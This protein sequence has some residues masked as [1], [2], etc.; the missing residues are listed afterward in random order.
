MTANCPTDQTLAA[1]TEG[2]LKRQEIASV[3][4]H[5]DTCMR[6]AHI[7]GAASQEVE[8]V[9]ERPATRWPWLAVA[10][11]AVIAIL[12]IPFARHFRSASVDDLVALAPHSARVIEPRLSGGFAYA[13]WRGP[14]RSD[15]GAR[16]AETMQLVGTAGTLMQRAD[17]D[18]SVEAQHDAGIALALV[19]EPLDAVTR[20][21]DAASRA[22][23]DARIWSD[24]AAAQYAAAERLGRPSMIPEALSSADRAVRVDPQFAEA[25]FN[26]AIIL[27]R[28]GLTQTA[29][30]A[31]QHY[32]D[33]DASSPWAAEARERLS[34]LPGTTGESLFRRDQPLLERAAETHDAARVANIVAEHRQQARTFGEAE[35]LGRWAEAKRRGD[36]AEATR[37]L[38]IAGGIGDALANVSGE[39]LL[40]DAVRAIA[41][42]K[43][44]PALA[45][46]HALY[47]QARMTY[48]RQQPSAAEP[49]LRRAATLFAR[50]GS[51]MAL[52]AR[53]FAA[54]ARYDRNDVD[55]AEDEL[56]ALLAEVDARRGAMALGAQVRWQ[57]ALCRMQADDWPA[58]LP[59][60]QEAA[61]AFR[62]LGERG[63]L[64]FLQTL[65][66]DALVCLARPEEAW[67]ARIESFR[68]LSAEGRGDRLL[69]SVGG[70]ARRE[71]RAGRFESARAL[72]GIEEAADRTMRNDLLLTNA[73]TREA[74]LDS[75]LG[76]DKS[77]T[78]HA[79]EAA[80]VAQ[81]I[82]DGA[83][84]TRA[85]I[86]V[87]FA[88]GAVLLAKDPRAA[89]DALTRAVDGYTSVE[90]PFYLPECYLLRT[91]ARMR[92]GDLAGAAA[93][94]ESGIAQLERHRIEYAGAV[95]GSGIFD[96]GRALYREAMSLALTRHD[97]PTA[98]AYAERSR[99]HAGD[100]PATAEEMRRRLAGSGTAV[101][102]IAAFDDEVVTFCLTGRDLVVHRV[103]I[104]RGMLAQLA[105]RTDAAARARL[106]DVLVRPSGN[107]IGGARHLV[108]VSDPELEGLAFGAL[109]D[110]VSRAYL[111]ER[112]A[113]S[114]AISASSLQR[115]DATRPAS[116]AAVAL[117]SGEA[118][119]SAAL[120][121]A[122]REL[123]AVRALYSRSISTE[124]ASISLLAAASADVVH[125]A[126]HTQRRGGADEAGLRFGEREWASWRSI[127]ASRFA[128][129]STIVLAACQS[130][131]R[132][133]ST[134]AFALSL[135]DAFLAAG[136]GD[137][138]GTL[139]VIA[140]NDAYE[141]FGSVHR[142]LAAGASADDAVRRAQLAILASGRPVAWQAVAVL[143][144]RI[145]TE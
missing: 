80:R 128:P 60:V 4:A 93:D 120:P 21:R 95:V 8:E 87:D 132:P 45:E 122:A 117:P 77:A 9:A 39:S 82:A 104:T 129:T 115:I 111:V 11:A 73:L 105:Q 134:H 106:Y 130:L 7:V 46:A 16:D 118:A 34:R 35:Y 42:T 61:R 79:D 62:A 136:A 88:R 131:R 29:R 71:L 3:V 110:S 56:V 27:E 51:P 112:L 140:D 44:L 116:V 31:W 143:T 96:A 30:D 103:R 48:G 113:V 114:S 24:L 142:E 89:I 17:R 67:T 138:I 2:R 12:S 58:S 32:L 85:L 59:L 22:P 86:D 23:D 63:N 37:L 81:R 107:A 43:E 123:D 26:R 70:A 139:D 69:V 68:L 127:A 84:R 99:A 52:M 97:V 10:A 126:G 74:A 50:T 40:R 90:R 6:C 64:G 124:T 19:G 57:L 55:G 65:A 14:I 76:D 108:I 135:G 72:L 25:L 145:P 15:A 98:F 41:E 33:V 66:G 119:G 78:A 28:L 92:I 47:R 49:E 38:T 91:R 102:E 83:L 141:L 125:I 13:P 18:H 20:L 54:S 75:I 121:Q 144:N 100:T 137:V 133:G 1:F 109:Y 53:Y 94:A 36:D 5:L 101:L